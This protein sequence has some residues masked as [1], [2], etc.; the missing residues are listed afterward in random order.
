M[1]GP[2]ERSYY[3]VLGVAVNAGAREIQQVSEILIVP[4]YL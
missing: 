4:S 3:E 2:R 1:S